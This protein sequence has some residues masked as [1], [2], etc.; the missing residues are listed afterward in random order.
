MKKIYTKEEQ[1]KISKTM[2]YIVEDMFK[3]YDAATTDILN[4]DVSRHI[5]LSGVYNLI[6]TK[7][8]IKLIEYEEIYDEFGYAGD[9]RIK[10][11]NLGSRTNKKVKSQNLKTELAISFIESY[12]IIRK[13]LY[14]MSKTNNDYKEKIMANVDEWYNRFE[15]EARIEFELPKTNNQY[16]VEVREENGQTI[17]TFHFGDKTI[18]IIT[19]GEF[20]FID[21]RTKEIKKVK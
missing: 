7:S 3:L 13:K 11:Y 14:E 16:S 10:A 18:N 9:K 21:K 2:Q 5:T 20:N 12:E 8:S 1:E 4:L 6:I 17:G 15:Q 19:R